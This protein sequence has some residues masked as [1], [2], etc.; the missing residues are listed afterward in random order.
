MTVRLVRGLFL[1]ASLAASVERVFV[2]AVEWV[3]PFMGP[4]AGLRWLLWDVEWWL[5][6]VGLLLLKSGPVWC[7]N[8]VMCHE[9]VDIVEFIVVE[10]AQRAPS[11]R[12]HSGCCSW[13]LASVVVLSSVAH[14]TD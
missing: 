12:C 7:D 2:A 14:L 4:S 8:L 5:C 9:V 6:G 10:S 1:A 11:Q 13:R 3:S